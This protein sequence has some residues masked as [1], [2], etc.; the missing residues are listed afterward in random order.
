[1]P[2]SSTCRL[3]V[4]LGAA[5]L[6]L[7]V[8]A[9][10]ARSQP[11]SARR[12]H[13]AWRG[14]HLAEAVEE[15]G[16][17]VQEDPTSVYVWTLHGFLL[18]RS[19][20]KE[21]ALAAYERAAS[22]DPQDPVVQNNR[23]AVL[24]DL[25][26]VEEARAAIRRALAERPGYADAHN[27]LGVTLE[28]SGRV[29]EASGSYEAATEADP[30]HARAHTN[31]GTLALR[32][33]RVQEARE[34][35]RRANDL[36]PELGA[37]TL[38]LLLLGGRDLV[39]GDLLERL[40]AA[41]RAPGA[42]PEVR[43]RALAA[44]AGLE[45][46]ERRFESARTLY[47]EALELT[48]EDPALLNNLAVAEDQLGRDREAILHLELALA[49]RPDLL[50]ARNNTGIV[51]VHRGSL[52]LAEDV[53]RSVLECDPD[54]HRAH[55]NLGVVL[56]ALGRLTEA[57]QS[58]QRAAALAPRDAEVRYNLGL[59]RRRLGGSALQ[60]LR[61]YEEA[62]RLDPDLAEA[63]LSL[64]CF[65]ADPQTPYDLR[66]EKRARIHL[67]RFL[68]TVPTHDEEGGAQAK[69]WLAWLERPR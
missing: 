16:R 57:L 58:F 53:F 52:S 23:G 35:F 18:S 31:L 37:P 17:A 5:L 12:A 51:H 46:R 15:S 2:T 29:S 62:L 69:A 13:V 56:A 1:M 28:R 39:A 4:L 36:D 50:V 19:G 63:H 24:L 6:L 45:T 59:L 48:P 43:A 67:E 3:V 66:D 65:L 25:G 54:F 60:E 10:A 20:R 27:N 41:A 55:Y 7:A 38:N 32:Q 68:A 11:A 44:L 34:C 64:G 42:S 49:H 61:A 47:L 14:G 21:E 30:T 9:R 40:Q 22:L 33:G 8:G 26:R